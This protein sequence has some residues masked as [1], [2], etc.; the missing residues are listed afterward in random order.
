MLLLL[1]SSVVAVR[2][3]HTYHALIL[4]QQEAVLPSCRPP[5]VLL[6]TCCPL[7]ISCSLFELIEE[8]LR[9]SYQFDRRNSAEF[10]VTYGDIIS[11]APSP[12]LP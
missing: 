8:E 6:P 5:A 10:L 1:F 2:T 12:A 4:Q 3:E 9:T 11:F 7:L